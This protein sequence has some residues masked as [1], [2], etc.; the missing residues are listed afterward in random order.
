MLRLRLGFPAKEIS[1][2][3]G[4]LGEIRAVKKAP[5]EVTVISP[6]ERARLLE[7]LP[8]RVRLVAE[9]LYVTGARVSE[10]LGVRR[11]HVKTNGSVVLRLY[12]KGGKEMTSRIPA[13]LCSRILEQFPE[14]MYLFESR[15]GQHFH[16]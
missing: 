13:E 5:P 1:L 15:Q 11:D 7:A 3:R 6:E 16:T 9:T 8:L 12:G 4:A 10:V 14:G 2:I